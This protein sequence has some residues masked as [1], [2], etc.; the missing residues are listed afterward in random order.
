ML[1][2]CAV[3]VAAGRTALLFSG[4]PSAA[5]SLQRFRWYS[6]PDTF[7]PLAVDINCTS[8]PQTSKEG[9]AKMAIDRRIG[10]IGSGQVRSNG[11]PCRR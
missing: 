3:Q 4:R 7:V 9:R 11:R 10:F 2:R 5:P 8:E 1:R 6:P